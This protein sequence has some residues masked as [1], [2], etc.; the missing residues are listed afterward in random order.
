VPGELA[1]IVPGRECLHDSRRIGK[2]MAPQE[3]DGEARDEVLGLP[4]RC[5]QC[6]WTEDARYGASLRDVASRT[7]Y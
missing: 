3:A 1:L 5:C 6:I 2:L 4:C 7:L